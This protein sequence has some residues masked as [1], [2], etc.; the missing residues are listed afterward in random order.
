M[1]LSLFTYKWHFVSHSR[2]S[3]GAAQR[4]ENIASAATKVTSTP[5]AK[6]S[7]RAY[8]QSDFLVRAIELWDEAKQNNG[9]MDAISEQ[10]GFCVFI[11]QAALMHCCWYIS[12]LLFDAGVGRVSGNP[13]LP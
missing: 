10:Q 5:N 3:R 12:G 6:T 1:S 7:K 4:R 13:A 11:S 9:S 2:K 8:R